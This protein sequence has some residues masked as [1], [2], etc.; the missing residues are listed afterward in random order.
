MIHNLREAL[1]A[2]LGVARRG[3]PLSVLRDSTVNF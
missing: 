1:S 2:E 3:G